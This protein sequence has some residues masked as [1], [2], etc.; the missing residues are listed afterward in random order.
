MSKKTI[1]N[2]ENAMRQ[3]EIVNG[4]NSYKLALYEFKLSA[5]AGALGKPWE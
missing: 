4:P 3:P 5:D 2:K 1:G